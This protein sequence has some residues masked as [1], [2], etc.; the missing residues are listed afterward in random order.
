MFYIILIIFFGSSTAQ[1]ASH[2]PQQFLAHI[3]GSKNE[4]QQ[5]VEHFCAN[6]HALKP[7]INVG[8]PT[9][10][11]VKDWQPRIAAGLDTLFVNASE[12]MN[13]MPPRGGCFECSDE[14]LKLAII[15]LLPKPLLKPKN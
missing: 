3:K 5:I 8:A 7:L 14:Q 15:A 12:G 10:K 9:A 2:H 4:G 1:A 13:A 11:N 6:C